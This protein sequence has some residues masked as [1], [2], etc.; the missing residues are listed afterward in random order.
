ML[1]LL[2]ADWADGIAE[3][4]VVR[5]VIMYPL[6]DANSVSTIGGVII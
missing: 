2:H 3:I 6:A 4:A 5:I 1:L